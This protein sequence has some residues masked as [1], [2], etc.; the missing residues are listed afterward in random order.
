[1]RV[2]KWLVPSGFVG[3]LVLAVVQYVV[4]VWMQR[5]APQTPPPASAAPT[6]P[7][8]QATAAATTPAGPGP[9]TPPGPAPRTSA[10]PQPSPTG[11]VVVPFAFDRQGP[12]HWHATITGTGTRPAAGTTAVIFVR[13]P[14]GRYY[15]EQPI[16]F[17]TD[18]TW[19]AAGVCLGGTADA[20]ATFELYARLVTDQRARDLKDTDGTTYVVDAPDGTRLGEGTVRR[21]GTPGSCATGPW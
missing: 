4:P 1:M 3:L 7:P 21:D 14:G 15:Y 17:R 10:P 5:A 18:G 13:P 6:V 2:L 20:T 11:P 9:G 16:D 8:P 12:V 19:S